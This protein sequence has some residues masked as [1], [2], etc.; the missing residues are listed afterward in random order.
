[1]KRLISITAHLVTLAIP[2]FLLM[3][4]IRLM[5]TPLFLTV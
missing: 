3:T 2:V 1:M 5:F 4:S